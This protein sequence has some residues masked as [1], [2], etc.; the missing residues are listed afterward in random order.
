MRKTD[1]DKDVNN[2]IVWVFRL[3][4]TKWDKTPKECAQVFKNNNLYS[5]ISDGY[6]YLHLMSYKSV[7]TELEEILAARGVRI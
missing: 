4:Q 2:M 6:D 5:A 1:T 3:A 7:V